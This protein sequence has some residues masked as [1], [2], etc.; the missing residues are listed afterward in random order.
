MF[1]DGARPADVARRLGVG[2][3][4]AGRWYS[5][6]IAD[7]PTGYYGAWQEARREQ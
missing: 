2:S 7:R 6:W 5:G 4:T 3:T 1:K